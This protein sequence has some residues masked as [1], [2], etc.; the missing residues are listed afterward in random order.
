MW[1]WY[2]N[3]DAGAH[4]YDFTKW[5]HDLI[6]INHR[7]YDPNEIKLVK[8]FSALADKQFYSK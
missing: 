1:T 8:E 2:Y 7:P 4:N 5:F 6:R 3:G